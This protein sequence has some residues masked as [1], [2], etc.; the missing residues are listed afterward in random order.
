MGGEKIEAAKAAA[1]RIVQKMADHDFFALVAFST[2]AATL[3]KAVQV[4][5]NRPAILGHIQQLQAGGDTYLGKGLQAA[6]GEIGPLCKGGANSTFYLLTDGAV[7]DAK[8]CTDLLPTIRQSGIAV[9]AGGVGNGYN[10]E[11]LDQICAD[12]FEK[13]QFLVEHI[14]LK[15]LQTL[16]T[17]FEQYLAKRGHVVTANCRL[18]VECPPMRVK[19]YGGTAEEHG[20]KLTFDAQNTTLLPDLPADEERVFWI[21]FLVRPDIEQKILLARFSLRYDLPMTGISQVATEEAAHLEITR[22]PIRGNTIN[23]DVEKLIKKIQGVQMATAASADV[24]NKEV[25]MAVKK[26]R[27]T[28]R[29]FKEL[30]L[31]KEAKEFAELAD[32]IEKSTPEQLD[33]HAKELRGK[34]KRY[35]E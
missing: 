16:A 29:I 22:D 31:E 7:H 18:T 9:Y 10:Q 5:P 24:A 20:R 19:L 33:G 11:F 3:V 21:E 1:S 14:S 25:G 12:P 13:G 6:I 2:E 15:E 4:G 34:T 30:G 32:A 8:A 28:T 23:P 17:A 35:S 27:G 26:L